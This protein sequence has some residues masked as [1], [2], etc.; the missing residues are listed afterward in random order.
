MIHPGPGWVMKSL[1]LD[2]LLSVSLRD[3]RVDHLERLFKLEV[4]SDSEVVM[5]LFATPFYFKLL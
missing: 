5:I 4:D 2:R 1:S 3:H